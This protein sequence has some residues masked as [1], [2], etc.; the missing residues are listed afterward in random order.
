MKFSIAQTKYSKQY[1]W[2]GIKNIYFISRNKCI[3]TKKKNRVLACFQTR[4][5]LDNGGLKP[6][7]AESFVTLVVPADLSAS[8]VHN[9]SSAG[10]AADSSASSAAVVADSSAADK[11][12]AKRSVMHLYNMIACTTACNPLSYKGYGCYCGLLGDGPIV[13]GIDR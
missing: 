10:A 2:Y 12:R 9:A 5:P 3:I 4:P 8:L 1:L 7:A 6:S 11:R 13:D